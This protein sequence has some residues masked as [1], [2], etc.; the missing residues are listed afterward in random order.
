M[1]KATGKGADH[2]F[3]VEV[4][5]VFEVD[6]IGVF[7]L[8]EFDRGLLLPVFDGQDGD[9]HFFPVQLRMVV[10]ISLIGEKVF[11]TYSIGRDEVA[12]GEEGMIHRL[13]LA[14]IYS[15]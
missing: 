9:G 2:L 15:F 10:I 4:C 3:R 1:F 7:V 12:V 6:E 8:E 11:R 13:L 14:L 5:T